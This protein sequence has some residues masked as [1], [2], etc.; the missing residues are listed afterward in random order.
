MSSQKR[1]W[2]SRYN[3]MMFSGIDPLS[4]FAF[5]DGFLR[6]ERRFILYCFLEN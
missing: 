5:F 2:L 4:I 6:Q 1:A 3:L